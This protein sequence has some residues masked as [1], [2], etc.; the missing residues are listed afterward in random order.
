M[1]EISY[2]Y[3]IKMKIMILQNTSAI[4]ACYLKISQFKGMFSK[5]GSKHAITAIC[6]VPL[7]LVLSLKLKPYL[8]MLI[9]LSIIL[10]SHFHNF[11]YYAHRIYPIFSKLCLI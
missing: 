5:H 1:V 7:T 9:N 3:R 2:Q 4:T 8:I 6:P 10:L 11:T